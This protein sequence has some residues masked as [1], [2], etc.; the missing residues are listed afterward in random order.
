[1]ARFF[2]TDGKYL[3]RVYKEHLSDFEDWDEGS[4]RRVGALRR[5]WART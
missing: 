2:R 4:C 1:M 3:N 5:I